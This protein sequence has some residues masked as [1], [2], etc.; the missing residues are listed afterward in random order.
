MSK[1]CLFVLMFYGPV[2]SYGHVELVSY[3]LTLFLCIL[4]H[5]LAST[6]PVVSDNCRWVRTTETTIFQN[7]QPSPNR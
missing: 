3:P 6:P 5:Y 7:V 1:G 4:D 2:N